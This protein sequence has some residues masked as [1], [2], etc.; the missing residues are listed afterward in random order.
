MKNHH[1]GIRFLGH[2]NDNKTCSQEILDPHLPSAQNNTQKKSFHS[3]HG[4][5]IYKRERNILLLLPIGV[6]IE[7]LIHGIKYRAFSPSK[8]KNTAPDADTLWICTPIGQ[9]NTF[10]SDHE[11]MIYKTDR[12]ILLLLPI[13]VQFQSVSHGIKHRAFSLST[14]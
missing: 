9:R 6:E 10:C 12:N 11:N 8:E 14:E 2:L 7:K 3:D 5:M 4:N 1:I 13:G